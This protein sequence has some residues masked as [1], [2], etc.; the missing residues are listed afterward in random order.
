M[1]NHSKAHRTGTA[2][3][4]LAALGALT[5]ATLLAAP[6]AAQM[7]DPARG[8]A[9]YENHCI[10]CHTERIHSRP[11]RI[12]LTREELRKIVE[13]WR[14]E[15]NL[16]WSAQDTEDV[17]EF[18]GRTRYKFPSPVARQGRP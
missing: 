7:P 14:R 11:M 6:A 16:T 12:A 2:L 10:V 9:L 8:R 17:V 13:H 1:I 18:L 4:G 5:I 15:Q 3:R